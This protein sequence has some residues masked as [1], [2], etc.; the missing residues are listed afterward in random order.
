MELLLPHVGGV[1]APPRSSLQ[2]R[3]HQWPCPCSTAP[4][5][6]AADP[7][8][9]IGRPESAPRPALPAS[10]CPAGESKAVQC[11]RNRCGPCLPTPPSC[12]APVSARRRVRSLPGCRPL[13]S[14]AAAQPRTTSGMELQLEDHVQV[15][16]ACSPGAR[17]ASS[18]CKCCGAAWHGA[19]VPQKN[20]RQKASPGRSWHWRSPFPGAAP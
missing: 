14:C 18:L 20:A 2:R 7:L 4:W 13:R 1:M 19:A 8:S 17:P 9:A 11:A 6:P 16:M 10:A 15:E 5:Q 3:S 12:A